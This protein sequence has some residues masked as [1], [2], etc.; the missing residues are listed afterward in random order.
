LVLGDAA[1]DTL[2]ISATIQGATP[3][4]FE[5]GTA[6][7]YET[8]FAITNPSADRTITFP[9]ATLTVNAAANISGATLASNVVTSSL[10]TVGSSTKMVLVLAYQPFH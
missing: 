5:G 2:T 7:D 10:T 9:D 6:G 1:L 4:V 3:L 8:S